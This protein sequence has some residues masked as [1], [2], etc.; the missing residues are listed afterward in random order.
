MYEW[1]YPNNRDIFFLVES[2][3]EWFPL[4][5]CFRLVA[6]VCCK[7][8]TIKK[9]EKFFY[10]TFYNIFGMVFFLSLPNP[11]RSIHRP[12]VSKSR[13]FPSGKVS[14]FAYHPPKCLFAQ[15][16]WSH[17]PLPAYLVLHFYCDVLLLLVSDSIEQLS[18]I[19]FSGLMKSF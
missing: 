9:N 18:I 11:V 2:T 16:A 6:I 14:W 7:K 1:Q 19:L 10:N 5:H 15:S 3:T 13:S 17:L 4:A 12:W 8:I